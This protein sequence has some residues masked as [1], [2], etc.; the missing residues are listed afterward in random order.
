[1]FSR[2]SKISLRA[3]KIFLRVSKIPKIM[4]NGT[5]DSDSVVVSST[6]YLSVDKFHFHSEFNM[7]SVRR[8]PTPDQ[9]TDRINPDLIQQHDVCS[10][11]WSGGVLNYYPT[12]TQH[13][14]YSYRHHH[15]LLSII[16][17][18]LHFF[19]SPIGGPAATMGKKAGGR[20]RVKQIGGP[21]G[22]MPS[23]PLADLTI[24]PDEM[25]HL[26]P[27]PDSNSGF[28]IWP[29]GTSM[30]VMHSMYC[31]LFSIYRSH[32]LNCSFVHFS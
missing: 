23:N 26:P 1:M 20:V 30:T 3:S 18:A 15:L 8:Q 2:A 9:V 4:S 24:P 21:K 16:C 32:I 22:G 27:K 17:T 14:S 13:Y 25:I 7:L 29:M 31:I 12:P 19:Y 28:L 11:I 10:S 6:R 5:I